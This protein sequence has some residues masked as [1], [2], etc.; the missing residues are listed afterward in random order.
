MLSL[1]HMILLPCFYRGGT[2][3]LKTMVVK[4][5]LKLTQ[6]SIVMTVSIFSLRLFK[7]QFVFVCM[8]YCLNLGIFLCLPSS[9]RDLP[10]LK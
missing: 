10:N 5:G 3:G 6:V 8:C 4:A 7:L 9:N 2:H 1:S